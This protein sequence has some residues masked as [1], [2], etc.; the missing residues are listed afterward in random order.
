MDTPIRM[1]SLLERR[2]NLQITKGPVLNHAST[3]FPARSFVALSSGVLIPVPTDGVLL[4]GWAPSASHA[5]TGTPA[6]LWPNITGLTVA[7]KP[8]DALYG[9]VHWP[10]DP[11]DCRFLMNITDASGNVGQ[12]AGAPTLAE[13]IIGSS[14]AVHRTA[15]GIQMLDVDDTTNTLF[16]VVGWY[17]GQASTDYNGLVIVEPI[18]SKIQA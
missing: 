12:T 4:Y 13:A 6:G 9:P 5:Y 3:T 10:F 11:S 18:V 14:F 17:P 16:K 15:A 2:D 8:P 7:D 1:P